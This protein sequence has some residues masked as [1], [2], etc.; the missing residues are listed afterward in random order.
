MAEEN[1]DIKP[2]DAEELDFLLNESGSTGL[3]IQNGYVQEDLNRAMQFPQAAKVYQEMSETSPVVGSM[4]FAI[5]MLVR[6]VVWSA[7]AGADTDAARANAAHLQECLGDTEKPFE[8]CVAEFMTMLV[9]GFSLNYIVLKKRKGK[10][11]DKRFNS[12]YKDGRWGFRKFPIRAQSTIESWETDDSNDVIGAVQRDPVTNDTSTLSMDQMLHFRVNTVKDNPESVS[13]LRRAHKPW[14]Y[15]E[16]IQRAEAISMT[17]DLQGLPVFKLPPQFM[18]KTAPS[19]ERAFY[20]M[21]KKYAKNIHNGKQGAMILPQ[22]LDPT[23]G[24]ELVTVDLLESKG[25]KSNNTDKIIDRLGS[26]ILQTV[27]ADFIKMG[28]SSVGSFALS[29]NKTKLFSVAVGSWLK[30]VINSFQKAIDLLGEAEGWNP[31][32]YPR[33]AHSDLESQDLDVVANFVDKMVKSGVL[34]PDQGL[35]DLARKLVGAPENEGVSDEDRM[36]T[37]RGKSEALINHES[38]KEEETIKDK[39]A[40]LSGGNTLT[41]SPSSK[42]NLKQ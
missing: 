26:E 28:S 21:V 3:L 38:K 39:S 19:H 5:E 18:S 27:L 20:Q 6:T 16:N 7:E 41:A 42:S 37:V 8:D 32:E 14:Y 1:E 35:E 34:T 11:K 12:K 23:S 30:Q 4:L 33:L 24:K 10:S 25:S 29:S 36:K 31:E 9:H 40:E 15:L 13:I 17:R 2:I 22:M